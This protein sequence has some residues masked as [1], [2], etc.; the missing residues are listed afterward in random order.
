M[1]GLDKAKEELSQKTYAQIQ[2]ETAWTWSSRACV[3][4]QNC[5]EEKFPAKLAWWSMGEEYAHESYE[6][7]ALTVESPNLLQQIR[8]AVQPYQEAASNSMGANPPVDVV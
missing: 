2:E 1:V 7:A 8:D 5:V 3:C 4:Y 6:H